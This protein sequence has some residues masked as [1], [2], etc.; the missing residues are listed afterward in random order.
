MLGNYKYNLTEVK[1]CRKAT[2]TSSKDA[3]SEVKG[4]LTAHIDF[5]YGED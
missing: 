5:H 2:S 4:V 3:E 1:S